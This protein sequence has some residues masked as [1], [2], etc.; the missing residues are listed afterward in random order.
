[1][2]EREIS[3]H[4]ELTL[5]SVSRC[6]PAAVLHRN[7][8]LRAITGLSN[9]YIRLGWV[10]RDQLTGPINTQTHA[11]CQPA[12]SPGEHTSAVHFGQDLRWKQPDSCPQPQKHSMPQ[13]QWQPGRRFAVRSFCLRRS[14]SPLL[15]ATHPWTDNASESRFCQPRRH[16]EPLDRMLARYF[17]VP[18]SWN[19]TSPTDAP[20]CNSHILLHSRK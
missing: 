5:V 6:H 18:R 1:M 3:P 20:P 14:G 2:Q 10:H 16:R 12:N 11:K 19:P 7:V 17:P 9:S 4:A 15:V 13:W 8:K